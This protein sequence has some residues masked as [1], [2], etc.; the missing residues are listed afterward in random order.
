MQAQEILKYKIISSDLIEV[1]LPLTKSHIIRENNGLIFCSVYKGLKGLFRKDFEETKKFGRKI[2][3]NVKEKLNNEGFF[4]SDE[5]P[6]YGIT[7]GETKAILKKTKAGENNLVAIFV[8]GKEE[9]QKTKDLL[10][11]LL[12]QARNFT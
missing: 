4:T 8:Y 2:C 9:A 10:D 12:R 3:Y 7:E 6:N 11:T 5:L 1:K